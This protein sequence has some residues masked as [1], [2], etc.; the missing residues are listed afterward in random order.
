VRQPFFLGT[1]SVPSPWAGADAGHGAGVVLASVD[2]DSGELAVGEARSERNPAFVVADAARSRL[3]AATE[4]EGE[5]ELVSW[6]VDADGSLGLRSASGTSS[7]SSC[8]V[9]ID[10]RRSA[11]YVAHFQGGRLSVIALAEDGAPAGLASIIS[12]PTQ[13]TSSD[14]SPVDRTG[15]R[16]RP[17][18]SVL[19]G[20]E[21]LMVTDCGRSIVSL[22]RIAGS[23]RETTLTLTASLALAE[24]T[25][26]RH[27]AMRT[28]SEFAY[29]SNEDAASISVLRLGTSGQQRIE[30][31]ETVPSPGLGRHTSLPSEIAIHPRLDVV[32]MANRRDESI[33]VFSVDPATG[34]LTHRQAVD[35]RGQWPRHFAITPDGGMLVV[36]NQNTDSLVSFR[37]LADGNLE[38]TGH[39]VSVAS[40]ASIAYWSDTTDN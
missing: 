12:L 37:V 28:N 1:Y 36:G 34:R 13:S 32:Y 8:H 4:V 26:A 21:L 15:M 35:T 3:Y 27:I 23:G 24:G 5:G 33:S 30:L 22:Y 19:V 17:H 7:N 20:P 29:V 10:P 16:S 2:L 9:T 40:P 14:G 39:E 25:G 11:A 31:V 38:W 18:C 6:E